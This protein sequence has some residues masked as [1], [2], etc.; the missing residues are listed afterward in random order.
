MNIGKG[1]TMIVC[2]TAGRYDVKWKGG[3]FPDIKRGDYITITGRLITLDLGRAFV[4][5]G[6]Q[7]LKPK[8]L[9]EI[10][11]FIQERMG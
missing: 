9:P 3:I 11:K 1:Q 4:V 10:K 2:P 8:S 6:A 7:L 5:V